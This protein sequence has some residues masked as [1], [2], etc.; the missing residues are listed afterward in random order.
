[1]TIRSAYTSDGY[2]LPMQ[3]D[4]PDGVI[5]SCDFCGTDWNPY[6]PD[7]AAQ[8]AMTEG[9]QGS[10]LCVDCLQQAM[11]GLTPLSQ[12]FDCTLCLRQRPADTPAWRPPDRADDASPEAAAPVAARNPAATLCYDCLRLAAKTFHKDPDTPFRWNPADFPPR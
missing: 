10:V 12:P 9:H 2:R 7:P 8:P 11:Q 4:T 6:E 1:L 3:R 5:I